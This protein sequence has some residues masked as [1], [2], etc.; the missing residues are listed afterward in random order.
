M[1]QRKLSL[2]TVEGDSKSDE[3]NNRKNITFLAY[4]A[5]ELFLHFLGK[6][7]IDG[8]TKCA[9]Y[10]RERPYNW[11]YYHY[12]E[13]FGFT[14]HY[15]DEA[16]IEKSK[17]IQSMRQTDYPLANAF[18][19]EIIEKLLV[20]SCEMVGNTEA[21]PLVREAA[22]KVRATGFDY[23]Y[24]VKKLCKKSGDGEYTASVF[25]HITE[26]GER[27]CIEIKKK[28]NDLAVSYQPFDKP[29]YVALEDFYK[30]ACWDGH[31]FKLTSNLDKELLVI[32]ADRETIL[33]HR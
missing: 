10:F 30:K 20:K 22:R 23:E 4:S 15:L 9:I 21:I 16:S 25:R 3:A 2:I 7:C 1:K 26:N 6:V 18:Y 12:D 27:Y 31:L 13:Y 24:K 5:K 33:S 29:R 14:A 32:D 28:G 11:D 8:N 17:E 19:L